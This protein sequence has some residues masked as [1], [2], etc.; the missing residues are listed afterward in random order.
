MMDREHRLL[1]GDKIFH[2]LCNS[3]VSFSR[4]V[5]QLYPSGHKTNTTLQLFMTKS[6]R[7]EHQVS[8]MKFTKTEYE[9]I[10]N[11]I[12]REALQGGKSSYV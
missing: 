3:Q 5:A 10:Y 2:V 9:Y 12:K 7:C 6:R 11:Y 4:V 8:P 1:R